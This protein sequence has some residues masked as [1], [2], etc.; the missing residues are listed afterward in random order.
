VKMTK[1]LFDRMCELFAS[2]DATPLWDPGEPWYIN[3]LIQPFTPGLDATELPPGTAGPDLGG[4]HLSFVMSESRLMWDPVS[5]NPIVLFGP[6][7]DDQWIKPVNGNDNL[8][9]TLYGFYLYFSSEFDESYGAQL[10]PEPIEFTELDQA[11][12]I[13]PPTFEF[14]PDKQD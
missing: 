2:S 3:G 14:H 12:V 7:D 1:F 13:P 11:I 10:L 5:G 9:F 4:S 8:P 6:G